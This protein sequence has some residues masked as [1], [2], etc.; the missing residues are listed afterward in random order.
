MKSH[1]K[2]SWKMENCTGVC[3][4]VWGGGLQPTLEGL[5]EVTVKG[6]M[7]ETLKMSVLVFIMILKLS[8]STP[9]TTES[10]RKSL[11]CR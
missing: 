6:S 9:S 3:V 5:L 1:S 11:D 7:G 2:I 10:S 8:L 4:C